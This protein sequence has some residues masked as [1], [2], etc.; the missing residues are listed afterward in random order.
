[1]QV[2]VRVKPVMGGSEPGDTLK[3]HAHTVHNLLS[4]ADVPWGRICTLS[5]KVHPYVSA[6]I[7]W[8]TTC[9]GF[10]RSEHA[11]SLQI[12]SS[13]CIGMASSHG[14]RSWTFDHIAGPDISQEAFFAGASSTSLAANLLSLPGTL[15]VGSAKLCKKFA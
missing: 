7:S 9:S 4:L 6:S 5:C 14:P 10:M 3:A 12:I 2:V 13:T 15:H 11:G 8:S 1:M